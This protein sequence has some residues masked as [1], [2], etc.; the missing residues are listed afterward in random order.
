MVFGIHKV[1]IDVEIQNFVRSVYR[2][3]IRK[4][5]PVTTELRHSFSNEVQSSPLRDAQDFDADRAQVFKQRYVC[6]QLK[7]DESLGV[8]LRL[9]FL[10][11]AHP[12]SKATR[13]EE[14][15]HSAAD[16]R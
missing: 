15:T 3:K 5:S 1:S 4:R 14:M 12:K 6:D 11:F 13:S 8:G 9:L 2:T 7:S 16:F 10:P